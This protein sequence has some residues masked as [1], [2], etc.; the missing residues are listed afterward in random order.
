MPLDRARPTCPASAPP[1]S[2]AEASRRSCAP[3]LT[4]TSPWCTSSSRP[5]RTSMSRKMMARG[6]GR[7]VPRAGTEVL[8]LW[9]VFLKSGHKKMY[10]RGEIHVNPKCLQ[11][12]V[13]HAMGHDFVRRTLHLSF[14]VELLSLGEPQRSI[15]MAMGALPAVFLRVGCSQVSSL[16]FVENQ[17]SLHRH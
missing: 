10:C 2:G 17:T 1:G 7:R 9:M 8:D 13:G 4:T 14:K 3:R 16:V 12:N 5:R 6:L 11:S 15:Q